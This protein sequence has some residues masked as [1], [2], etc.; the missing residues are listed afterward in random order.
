MK[1]K[2]TGDYT[3]GA[4]MINAWGLTFYA[5]NGTEVPKELQD[6][7]DRHPEFE[8]VKARKKDEENG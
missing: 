4:T 3:N 1:F 2:F 7:F 5:R 8:A 6:K